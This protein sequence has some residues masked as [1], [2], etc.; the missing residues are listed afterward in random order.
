MANA[1]PVGASEDSADVFKRYL[2]AVSEHDGDAVA[3]LIDDNLKHDFSRDGVEVDLSGYQPAELVKQAGAY[4][5]DVHDVFGHGD[6][7]VARFSVT[8]SADAVEGAQA[9]GSKDVTAIAIAR[10]ENGKIVEVAHEM[11]TLGLLLDFGW[12][13]QKPAA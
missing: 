10:V 11:D 1:E 7:A 5:I 12:T 9:G 2:Q 13:L 3:D 6:K 4:D 8:V